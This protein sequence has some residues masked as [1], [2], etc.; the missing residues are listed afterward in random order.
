MTQ[1]EK[2]WGDMT[3]LHELACSYI[4]VP[5][6]RGQQLK[7]PGQLDGWVRDGSGAGSYTHLTRPLSLRVWYSGY[8]G[9]VN[10]RS[11]LCTS[12]DY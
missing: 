4:V 10:S 1:F 7:D 9:Q 2:L 12:S 8:A 3:S 6:R 11:D 5:M